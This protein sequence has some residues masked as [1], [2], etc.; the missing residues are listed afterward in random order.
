VIDLVD[1]AEGKTKLEKR[2]ALPANRRSRAPK[3]P[4]IDPLAMWR[5]LP[6]GAAE[7]LGAMAIA[8]FLSAEGMNAHDGTEPIFG[9]FERIMQ[10]TNQQL[11]DFLHL[12]FPRAFISA[13]GRVSPRLPDLNTLKKLRPAEVRWRAA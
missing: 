4:P 6:Q 2:R 12:L 10:E 13:N 9:T 3:V 11:G 7:Y 1:I 5:S 8:F